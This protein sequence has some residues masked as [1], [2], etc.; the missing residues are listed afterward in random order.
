VDRIT[1]PLLLMHGVND[2][3]VPIK[4][5]EIMEAAMR[6]AGKPVTVVRLEGEDHWLSSGATRTRMLQESIRFLETHNPPY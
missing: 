2:T 3:V 5:T 1:V 4:Q 6:R